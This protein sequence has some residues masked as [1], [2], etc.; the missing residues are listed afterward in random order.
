MKKLGSVLS[1]VLMTAVIML[2]SVVSFSAADKLTINGSVE[3]RKGDKVTYSLYISDVPELTE[4]VQLIIYYDS[5]ILTVVDDS[6]KYPQGGS[7]IYN[8][9]IDG[10]VLFNCANGLE[11]WDFKKRTLLFE[12]AFTVKQAGET[13]LSYYIQCLDYLSNSQPVDNYVLTCDYKVNDDAAENG[14]VPMLNTSGSGGSFINHENG[15]GEKNGGK[16]AV[17]PANQPVTEAQANNNNGNVGNTVVA[18][19]QEQTKETTV[20]K[21]NSSGV[22]VT[23][24]DGNET[25]W[26]DSKD[27]WRNIG[28]AVLAAAVVCCI[29]IIVVLNKRKTAEKKDKNSK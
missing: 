8:A 11:G 20:V 1:A 16:G 7:P 9:G 24:P 28:I 3:A 29:V 10:Q 15:K 2:T 19:T 4:D 23:D 18:E 26:S 14:A 6:I 17:G 22:A 13:D 5:Q 27:R 25:Y 12:V 21:T